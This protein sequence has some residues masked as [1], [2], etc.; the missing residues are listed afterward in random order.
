MLRSSWHTGLQLEVA[1]RIVSALQNG[2]LD[3]R[4]ALVRDCSWRPREEMNWL[5]EA[6]KELA[7][8][9]EHK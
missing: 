3:H 4:V 5:A 6:A 9:S 8:R 7:V 2:V 1:K